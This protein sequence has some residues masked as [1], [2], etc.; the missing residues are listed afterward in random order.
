MFLASNDLAY[1]I[2]PPGMASGAY[3]LETVP[4]KRLPQLITETSIPAFFG[5]DL[6]GFIDHVHQMLTIDPQHRPTAATA[7]QHA[8]LQ[9]QL[10]PP[11]QAMASIPED[12]GYGFAVNTK[13]SEVQQSSRTPIMSPVSGSSSVNHSFNSASTNDGS[14]ASPVKGSFTSSIK[15]PTASEGTPVPVGD[16]TSPI[17]KSERTGTA[18]TTPINSWTERGNMQRSG[19]PS[20]V[21]GAPPSQLEDGAKM[22]AST[23]F[24]RSS[25]GAV[26][27]PGFFL[28]TKPR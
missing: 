14:E 15:H 3:W 26:L 1:Q 21:F 4:N 23:K 13:M 9:A 6:N 19:A 7:T 20:W 2:D 11:S 12:A 18:C 22:H 28:G 27:T 5:D 10:A 25:Q 24:V 8:W 17:G 16:A